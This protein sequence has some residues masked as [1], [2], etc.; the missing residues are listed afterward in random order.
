MKNKTMESNNDV[1]NP[2]TAPMKPYLS[3]VAYD[4]PSFFGGIK[5]IDLVLANT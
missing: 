3:P 5:F 4:L 1:K 2:K